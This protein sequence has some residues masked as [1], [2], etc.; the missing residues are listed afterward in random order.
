MN[1]YNFGYLDEHTK[2]VIRRS[3]LKAVSIPG[4]NQ[5]LITACYELQFL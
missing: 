5:V 1:Q 2:R 3:L 4:G